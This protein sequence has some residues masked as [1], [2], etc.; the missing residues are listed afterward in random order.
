MKSKPL[1]YAKF[2]K[3]LTELEITDMF[4]NGKLKAVCQKCEFVN[5]IIIEDNFICEKCKSLHIAPHMNP[6]EIS[7]ERKV[8][9]E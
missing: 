7:V 1:L 5:E 8:K 3:E 4:F 2:P 6:F 9:N